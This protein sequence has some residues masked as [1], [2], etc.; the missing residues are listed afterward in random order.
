MSLNAAKSG[1]DRDKVPTDH[2]RVSPVSYYCT[3]CNGLAGEDGSGYQLICDIN[4]SYICGV[5]TIRRQRRACDR[6]WLICNAFSVPQ[7]FYL[8]CMFTRVVHA[9]Y[10]T[11]RHNMTLL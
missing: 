5:N 3:R 10:A 9:Y 2:Y 11:H 6:A 7:C 1:L 8:Q 4:L